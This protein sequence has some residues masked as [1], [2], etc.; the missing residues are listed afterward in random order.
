[1]AGYCTRGQYFHSPL[2]RK[3][4]SAHSY[5]IQPYSTFTG[6]IICDRV[7]ENIP[8]VIIFS[9]RDRGAVRFVLSH[10]VSK[11]RAS[12]CWHRVHVTRR[13]LAFLLVQAI[14]TM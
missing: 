10:T 9:Y 12:V 5:S 14:F 3:N 6:V 1:M 4:T 7:C 11:L 13:K 2:A 8:L